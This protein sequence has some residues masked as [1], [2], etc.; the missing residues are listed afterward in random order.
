[1]QQRLK[2][3]QRFVEATDLAQA[4]GRVLGVAFGG[5]EL[6]GPEKLDECGLP[7]LSIEMGYPKIEMPARLRQARLVCRFAG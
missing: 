2:H 5:R 4:D 3:E 6:A 1:M 7:F